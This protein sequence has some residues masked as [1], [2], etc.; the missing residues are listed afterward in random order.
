MS[1]L[2]LVE[3]NDDAR[4]DAGVAASAQGTVFCRSAYLRSLGM[5]FRRLAVV[6]GGKTLAL[7]PAVED[8]SG[9]CLVH[10]WIHLLN[11]GDL[12]LL[13]QRRANTLIH[14]VGE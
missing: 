4:W 5:P 3:V 1:A 14:P 6:C 11:G 13:F 10:Q 7:L 2:T 8:T 12:V 9:Q